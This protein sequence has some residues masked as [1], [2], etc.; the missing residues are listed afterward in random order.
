MSRE[1]AGRGGERGIERIDG[2]WEEDTMG[3]MAAFFA[4]VP[5]TGCG[6]HPLRMHRMHRSKLWSWLRST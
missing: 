2:L 6:Q 5:L 3:Q 4:S 1:A